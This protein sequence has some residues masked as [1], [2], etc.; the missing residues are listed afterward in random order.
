MTDT[1]PSALSPAPAAEPGLF[2]AG[3]VL[4]VVML[5]TFLSVLDT[6][7]LNV[8]LPYVMASFSSDV[9]HAKWVTAGLFLGATV[10]MPLSGWLSQRFG[11]GMV[12]IVSLSVFTAS[13]ALSAL[14]WSLDV[15]IAL[16]VIQGLAAG[17][18]QPTS[19]SILSQAYPPSMRG[20]IF[21]IWSIGQMTAPSVGPA[22]GGV[23]IELIDWRAIFVFSASVGVIATLSAFA[24]LDR[25]FEKQIRQ[26]DWLGFGVLSFLLV[27]SFL[28]I[29][30]GDREGWHSTIIVS[31]ILACIVAVPVLLLVEWNE[32]NAIMP[33]RLF[34]RRDFSL[35]AFI[36][37]YRAVGMMGPGF[38]LPIFMFNI[39][40]RASMDIGFMLMPGAVVMAASSPLAGWVTDRFG[41]R[42]PTVFGALLMGWSLYHFRYLDESTTFWQVA[43][44]LVAQGIGVA[45]VMT[46]IIT[47]GM[48]AAGRKDIG[49]ASWILNVCH[50]GG[51]AFSITILG[52]LL[53][54]EILK[55][56]HHLGEAPMLRAPGTAALEGV[57]RGMGFSN[58]G[59]GDA[60]LAGV[61]HNVAHAAST[62]AFEH[63]FLIATVTSLTMA[64]PALLLGGK[65]RAGL[66]DRD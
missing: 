60:A 12:Y 44:P 27:T 46:P 20:R 25:K 13:A 49:S 55:L 21:G 34:L 10:S 17:L 36:T 18:I 26:F 56:D 30:Y 59:A 15:L 52:A 61:L 29:T 6:T 42:W 14:A 41:G 48:N 50:R 62:V 5:G 11:H 28:V 66:A 51:G 40:G 22:A 63:M 19:V 24:V 64:I 58:A 23:I 3:W 45:F 2:S 57:A 53:E 4:P 8:A 43:L 33:L 38:L 31:G 9:D 1:S 39:Q 54:R 65:H 47:V 7:I 35:S 37:V 16:R 32:P